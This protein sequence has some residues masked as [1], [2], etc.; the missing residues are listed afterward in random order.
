MIPGLYQP[1][2]FSSLLLYTQSEENLRRPSTFS[3]KSVDTAVALPSMRWENDYMKTTEPQIPPADTLA[4]MQAVADAVAAGKPVDPE[5][6]RR[7]RSRSQ[8]VQ[9]ELLNR[10]GIR[11]IAVS[12]I[13][14]G[15]EEE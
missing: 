7:V 3:A 10:Y 9:Q 6:A 1:L 12:L 2:Q 14:Q 5:V 8:R 4:D 11:E 15:R 13:R